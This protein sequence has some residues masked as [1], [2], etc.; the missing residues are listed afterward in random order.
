VPGCKCLI[1]CLHILIFAFDLLFSLARNSLP[2]T[3]RD[4]TNI[5]GFSSSSLESKQ[6]SGTK[7]YNVLIADLGFIS[8]KSSKKRKTLIKK[9]DFR[10]NLK[11]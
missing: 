3:V 1:A 10:L 5:L 2:S 11:I 8:L 7:S 4:I 9:Y 6:A